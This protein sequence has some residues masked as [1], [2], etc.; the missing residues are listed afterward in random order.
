MTKRI[1][2]LLYGTIIWLVIVLYIVPALY[3][4]IFRG[5][6]L[7]IKSGKPIID[8]LSMLMDNK[9][10]NFLMKPLE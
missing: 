5:V 2:K 4:L 7:Y 10:L 8:S 6:F 3:F 9:F 1:F